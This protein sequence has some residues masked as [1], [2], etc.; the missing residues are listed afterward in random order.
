MRCII[1]FILFS[2]FLSYT[3]LYFSYGV[4]QSIVASILCFE[5]LIICLTF[6]NV[7]LRFDDALKVRELGVALGI[8]SESVWRHPFPGPGLA[9]R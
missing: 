4:S 6:L 3:F 5:F 1:I 7:F 9:I 8:A 2:Y